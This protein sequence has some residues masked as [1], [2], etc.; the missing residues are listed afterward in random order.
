MRLISTLIFATFLLA[1]IAHARAPEYDEAY[2]MFLTAGDPRPAWP[3]GVF[4]PAD[5]ASFYRGTAPPAV[6]AQSLRKLDVHPPLYF[7]ALE[8][9][10]RLFGPGWFTARLLSVAF[11][12]FALSALAWLAAMAEVPVITTLAIAVLTYGFAYTGIVARGFALGQLFNV[13]GAACLFYA[14]RKNRLIA[15]VL[16]GLAFGAA[17]FTNYLAVFT[18]L[19]G[20]FWLLLQSP[21]R[22]A[23]VAALGFAAFLPADYYFYAAQKSSRIGQFTRFS[24]PHALVTLAKDSGATLFGGLPVYAGWLAPL[25]TLALLVLLAVCL[26]PLLK[27]RTPATSLFALG[28]LAPPLGLLALCCVFNNTPI[29]IRYLAYATPFTALLLAQALRHRPILQTFLLLA[30]S[31]AII[32]L[33]FAPATM[34]PQARAARQAA[35]LANPATLTLLPYGNDGVGIPGP[36]IAS[37]PATLRLALI[38]PHHLPPLQNQQQ[39]TLVTLTI[40]NAS[41]ATTTAALTYFASHPCWHPQSASTLTRHYIGICNQH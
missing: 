32:G 8:Y 19:A 38:T 37:S 4:H 24:W 31:F 39:I 21:R 28:A 14:A 17:G 10:R 41:R 2:S 1:F 7:W 9:W 16:G 23:G 3:T 13:F 22:L 40:D 12:T 15:A 29:E 26:R 25:V 6:I 5:V 35:A 27:T 34:Q 36:F 30:E 11:T 33:A 20:L 18:A